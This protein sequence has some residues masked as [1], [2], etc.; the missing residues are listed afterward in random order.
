MPIDSGAQFD[1]PGLRGGP[2][3]P[4]PQRFRQPIEIDLATRA[5]KGDP[6]LNE[7]ASFGFPESGIFGVFDGVGSASSGL[8]A[9]HLAR[10]YVRDRLKQRS[11]GMSAIET[12]RLV[13]QSLLE[14]N[15]VILERSGGRKGWETTG[16]VGVIWEGPSG[17]RKAIIGH[18][19]DSRAYLLRGGVL[20]QITIDDSIGM[21]PG[22]QHESE[23]RYLQDKMSDASDPSRDLSSA[24]QAL[25]GQRNII[26]KSLGEPGVMPKMYSADLLPGDEL[27]IVSDGVS[28]NL[29]NT[30]IQTIAR[31]CYGDTKKTVA[32]IADTAFNA[33]TLPKERFARA[34][35]DDITTIVVSI[36]RSMTGQERLVQNQPVRTPSEAPKPVFQIRPG[37]RVYVHR[38]DGSVDGKWTF[39]G[40]D[41]EGMRVAKK[42]R[43][44][45]THILHINGQELEDLNRPTTMA[46]IRGLGSRSIDDLVHVVRRLQEGGVQGSKMFYPSKVQ[47]QMLIDAYY[48]D[49]P[50]SDIT[51]AGGLKQVLEQ[52][53]RLRQIR[54]ELS[55]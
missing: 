24:E 41:A 29:R 20:D 15:S 28:D 26:L 7:D 12:Q 25:F 42:D 8:E 55:R 38:E 54:G 53:M 5:K 31:N 10:D 39:E 50:L 35:R 48:G 16:T 37:S 45:V 3:H 51:S 46:D 34:K 52:H 11:V 49:I 21:I 6:R 22:E 43:H 30:A 32:D 47:E 9:S 40:Q 13:R 33:S 17:E 2:A 27:I 18:L 1:N 23:N 19:G 4:E 44:G 14:A 36:P